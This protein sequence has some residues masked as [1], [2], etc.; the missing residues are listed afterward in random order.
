MYLKYILN[1]YLVKPSWIY[2]NKYFI[3]YELYIF[4]KIFLTMYNIV[5]KYS[6]DLRNFLYLY[7]DIINI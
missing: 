1:V 7:K 6:E 4:T 3:E 2:I 5:L